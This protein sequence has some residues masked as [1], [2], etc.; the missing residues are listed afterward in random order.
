[1]LSSFLL[2]L[3]EG[4]EAALI[5][6]IVIGALQKF[7]RPG[8]ARAVWAGTACAAAL[9]LLAAIVLNIVG[10]SLEGKA[11]EIYE[12]ITMLA[13]AGVLTWMIF[14]MNHQARNLRSEL[15]SG[16]RRAAF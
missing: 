16:V 12:G 11:E 14:W 10:T 7:N 8:L 13:A 2:S 9:S 1:M 15:E 4:I 6:G 3:R 5:I